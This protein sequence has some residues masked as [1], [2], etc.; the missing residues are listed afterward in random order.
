LEYRYDMQAVVDIPGIQ[1]FDAFYFKCVDFTV[2]V[3]AHV[4]V[5]G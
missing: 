2:T 4:V 3:I 5:T 1:T